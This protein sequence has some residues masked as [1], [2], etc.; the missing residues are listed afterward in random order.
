M[1]D[2]NFGNPF[3]DISAESLEQAAEQRFSPA[4]PD[5]AAPAVE[6]DEA[7][8]SLSSSAEQTPTPEVVEYD[9]NGRRVAHAEV[10]AWSQFD[11][12]LRSDPRLGQLIYD[13]LHGGPT[14]VPSSGGVG[15]TPGQSEGSR[16]PSTPGWG[17][18]AT[19]P[20]ALNPQPVNQQQ[21]QI[22]P[23]LL[24]DPAVNFLWN[25]IQQ[26][27]SLLDN[28]RGEIQ[29]LSSIT[30][31]RVEADAKTVME[32]AVSEFK[33]SYGITDDNVV[34]NVKLA[35]ARL[36]VMHS[37][38]NRGIDPITGLPTDPNPLNAVKRAMEVAAYSIPEVRE[39]VIAAQL[40]Q[41]QS[42]FQRKQ[43]L[44]A[45]GGSTR[46]LP[47]NTPAPTSPQDIRNAMVQEVAAAMNGNGQE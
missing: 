22:D 26:Q 46:P 4:Q 34:N 6:E 13:Y 40:S 19:P 12:L 15:V 27:N 41:Q 20:P 7:S 16:V 25:Q 9:I 36:D 38:L 45:V 24:E 47:R 10:E 5:E 3:T 14:N 42:D 1:S 32:Q 31:S 37:I 11:N 18:P 44:N 17:S 2:L 33:E 30:S 43:R 29:R 28:Y 35:A 8:P 21:Q 23:A 39:Q